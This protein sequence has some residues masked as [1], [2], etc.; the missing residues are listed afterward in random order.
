MRS[1]FI[2]FN[3]NNVYLL[4]GLARVSHELCAKSLNHHNH[5]DERAN[6]TFSQPFLTF[7]MLRPYAKIKFWSFP[8]GCTLITKLKQTF[9][10]TKTWNIRGWTFAKLTERICF[11]WIKVKLSTFS[12]YWLLMMCDEP[13]V[14][15][16]PAWG[17]L[18][19]S[20]GF[21]PL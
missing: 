7:V 10:K 8:R 15:W 20:A 12:F 1:F 21:T 19:L 13:A 3:C 6:R 16:V 14:F 17:Q 2:K 9:I 4:F 5:D 11:S 18:S